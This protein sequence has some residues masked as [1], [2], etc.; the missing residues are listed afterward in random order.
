MFS[1]NVKC[2]YKRLCI[3]KWK[4]LCSDCENNHYKPKET[5]KKSY[6]KEQLEDYP[7][8]SHYP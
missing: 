5:K 1:N 3:D 8:E 7:F 4:S 6:Y 2:K